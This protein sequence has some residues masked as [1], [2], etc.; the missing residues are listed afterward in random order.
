MTF[1]SYI[2]RERIVRMRKFLAGKLS[3]AQRWTGRP[4]AGK[5]CLQ[6]TTRFVSLP[7]LLYFFLRSNTMN[8]PLKVKRNTWSI[9]EEK[10]FFLLCKEKAITDL[11]DKCV[12]SAGVAITI[13]I[14]IVSITKCLN[15]IGS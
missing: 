6:I 2:R 9:V 14:L 4:L 3:L 8:T 5:N 11:L 10:D 7:I 12:T 13:Y 1:A 15:M